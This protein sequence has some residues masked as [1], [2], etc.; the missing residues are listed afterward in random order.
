MLS[1]P[2][3]SHMN[4][5]LWFEGITNSKEFWIA[6]L[7]FILVCVLPALFSHWKGYGFFIGFF[8]ALITNPVHMTFKL[9]DWPSLRPGKAKEKEEKSLLTNLLT[10]LAYKFGSLLVKLTNCILMTFG[11]TLPA[12]ET[13]SFYLNQEYL[14]WAYDHLQHSSAD[15]IKL[16]FP[17]GKAQM[18]E[19]IIEILSFCGHDPDEC[20]WQTYMRAVQAYF[21][22][23]N[24]HNNQQYTSEMLYT[25]YRDIVHNQEAA[26]KLIE[27]FENS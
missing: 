23:I 26:I 10:H 19:I 27:L 25:S 14:R 24:N 4:S 16:A 17:G 3:L 13:P 12:P 20:T 15:E 8:G 18:G 1:F 5:D 22:I 11:V 2:I 6:L 7:L 9:F 21:E